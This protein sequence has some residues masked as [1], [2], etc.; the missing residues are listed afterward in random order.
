V[1]LKLLGNR[2]GGF[3]LR[4]LFLWYSVLFGSGEKGEGDRRE[5]QRDMRLQRFGFY[6]VFDMIHDIQ[7]G[8][9]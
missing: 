3:L 8:S 2:L 4:G 6:N 5:N 7:H 1:N 9:H